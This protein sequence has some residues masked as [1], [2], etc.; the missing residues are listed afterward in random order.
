MLF[1]LLSIFQNEETVCL[2]QLQ[3]STKGHIE[4]QEME[5][6]WKMEAETGNGNWKLKTETETQ[7]L[8]CCSPSKIRGFHSYIGIPVLSL[9]PVFDG[10]L[11]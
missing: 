4:K 1:P 2:M 9:P 5:M 8:S 11:C 10:L 6:K 3:C 7:P